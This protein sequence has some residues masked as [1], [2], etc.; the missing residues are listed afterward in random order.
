MQ[1]GEHARL[2]MSPDYGYGARGFP[3]WGIPGQAVLI[4]DIELLEIN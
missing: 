3:Q 2:E 4:F 1:L